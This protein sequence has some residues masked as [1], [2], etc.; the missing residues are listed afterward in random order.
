MSLADQ[1]A[2]RNA[3]SPGRAVGEVDEFGIPVP[4]PETPE[5][6]VARALLINERALEQTHAPRIHGLHLRGDAVWL[7]H[8]PLKQQVG[9]VYQLTHLRRSLRMWEVEAFWRVLKQ[10]LPHLDR[11]YIEIADGL[12]WDME[13][14]ILV[15]EDGEE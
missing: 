1:I 13:R 12:L 10:Y 7:G 9:V 2:E 11:R 8:R 14:A 15:S 5:Y 3:T 6:L 4:S